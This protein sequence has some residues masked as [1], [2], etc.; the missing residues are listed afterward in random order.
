MD[1]IEWKLGSNCTDLDCKKNIPNSGKIFD[2]F[3]S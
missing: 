1:K 2:F 3:N